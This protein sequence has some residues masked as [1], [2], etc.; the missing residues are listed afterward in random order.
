MRTTHWLWILVVGVVL[1][2]VAWL[3][4]SSENPAAPAPRMEAPVAETERASANESAVTVATDAARSDTTTPDSAR[5]IA[6]DARWSVQVVD[7]QRRGIAGATLEWQRSDERLRPGSLPKHSWVRDEGLGEESLRAV[8]GQTDATG[9]LFIAPVVR[10]D[11]VKGAWWVHAAGFLPARVEVVADARWGLPE[12]IE[13]T[14]ARSVRVCVRHT[15]GAPAAHAN[16]LSLARPSQRVSERTPWPSLCLRSSTDARGEGTLT[17]LEPE[18]MVWAELDEWQSLPVYVDQEQDMVELTLAPT[19]V[20]QGQV[21]WGTQTR[22]DAVVALKLIAGD[23]VHDCGGVPVRADGRFG[24]ARVPVSDGDELYANVDASNA[25]CDALVVRPLP[26]AG[27][28]VE[29][30]FRMGPALWTP[31]LVYDEA[32]QPIEGAHIELRNL[33][34]TGWVIVEGRTNAEGKLRLSGLQAGQVQGFARAR[35][36]APYTFEIML[37]TPGQLLELPLPPGASLTGRVVRAGEPVVDCTLAW[38]QTGNLTQRKRNAHARDGRFELE[39]LQAAPVWVCATTA[40]GERS[41]VI[42]VDPRLQPEDVVLELTQGRELHGRVVDQA[43]GAPVVGA[44]V[45]VLSAGPTAPLTGYGRAVTSGVDGH[46]RLSSAQA[47]DTVEASAPGYLTTRVLLTEELTAGTDLRLQ[48]GRGGALELK[49]DAGFWRQEAVV[50]GVVN[51]PVNELLGADGNKRIEGIVPGPTHAMIEFGYTQLVIY[52]PFVCQ[53]NATAQLEVDVSR[54]PLMELSVEP[55]GAASPFYRLELSSP[56]RVVARGCKPGQRFRMP[57]V[58]L[59]CPASVYAFDKLVWVGQLDAALLAATNGKVL[60]PAEAPQIAVVSS[61]TGSER[62]SLGLPFHFAA[63]L[64]TAAFLQLQP[65]PDGTFVLP[66]AAGSALTWLATDGLGAVAVAD[67]LEVPRA[68]R[69]VVEMPVE[70]MVTV[71][72]QL[73]GDA[74]ETA[75]AQLLLSHSSWTEP[76]LSALLSTGAPAPQWQLSRGRY[77]ATWSGAGIWP[78]AVDIAVGT[79]PLRVEV[80]VRALGDLELDLHSSQGT[81]GAMLELQDQLTGTAVAQWLAEGRVKGSGHVQSTV[82]ADEHGRVRLQ[83]LPSGRYRWRHGGV[84]GEIEVRARTTERYALELP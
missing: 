3:R 22:E 49:V 16:V 71:S 65:E 76:V 63:P 36:R 84:G 47:G 21:E 15:D 55:Q 77:R 14:A 13:M 68:E 78:G 50:V 52:E 62:K 35:G 4:L 18:L 37:H 27:S 60:L 46:Y 19:C 51:G 11:L 75:G 39:S 2:L 30:A 45:R 58:P 80:A 38:W 31:L 83:G 8:L 7:A 32:Q 66:H 64:G 69:G 73:T 41:A 42:E 48:I 29:H 82:Q 28:R 9:L 44:S 57:M 81:A 53:A 34:S 24:P 26:Q 5:T 56:T 67:R 20:V 33:Q 25:R 61:A 10:A 70:P 74:V 6:A 12:R 23:R 59:P 17:H 40:D 79:A 54:M 1:A 43:T 72:A